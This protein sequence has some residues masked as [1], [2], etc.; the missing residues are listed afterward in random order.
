VGNS[1]P[2]A[3]NVFEK[4]GLVFSTELTSTLEF[5]RQKSGEHEPYTRHGAR[6]V[7]AKLDET[8]VSREHLLLSRRSDDAIRVTNQS[9]V[10][11][12]LV[13]L[14]QEIG[15]GKHDDISLP[16]LV[17]V[18][19]RVIKLSTDSE[20]AAA[21]AVVASLAQRTAPPGARSGAS[22]AI[23]QIMARRTPGDDDTAYV[24]RGL[25]ATIGVLQRA[26]RTDDFA[27]LAVQAMVDDLGFEN[28]ASL[29]WEGGEWICEV[30]RSQ[31]TVANDE[32]APSRT[33]LQRVYQEKR[34]FWKLPSTEESASPSLINVG[35]LTAAPILDRDG[36][37]VGALYG[38]RPLVVNGKI[39]KRI[40]EVEASIVEMLSTS[41]AAGLARLEQEHAAV[42][43]RVLFEQ[44]FTPEL[45]RQLEVEPDLLLGKDTDVSLL[46][47]DIQGLSEVSEQLGA[48]LTLDWINDVVGTLSQCVADNHGVVVDTLG[49]ELMGMW[50]APVDRANHAELACRAALQMRQQLP[51]LNHRWRQALQKPVELGIGIHTGV[52]RVGNIGSATKFKYGPLGCTVQAARR[53]KAATERLATNVL[54]SSDTAARLSDEFATRRLW[55]LEQDEPLGLFE[56]TTDVPDD[57]CELKRRFE[58]ALEAYERGDF[59][60]AIRLL[61]KILTDHPGDRPSLQ[62][63][64]RTA[65]DYFA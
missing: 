7:I 18:F 38:E 10:N 28:A 19:G 53:V 20:P 31:A 64:A 61:A 12:V 49:D 57:W 58:A 25:E 2:V 5:G 24:L 26:G 32:W 56:L 16:A 47:C 23:S 13:N 54:I 51:Q 27:T 63:L 35:S 44:F 41:I 14:E 46:F 40:T 43:A 9:H 42:K 29:R 59:P 4:Q 30:F 45:S 36:E 33:I 3:V 39:G 1:E 21:C 6:V 65:G 52:A 8:N 17:T 22:S 50:G 34:T 62:L 60:T 37:V 48:R 55:L 11:S 15:P